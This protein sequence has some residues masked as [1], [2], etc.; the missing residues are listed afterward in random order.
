MFWMFG[1][2]IIGCGAT[3]LME[4]ITNFVPAYRL[5]GVVK[6]LT[7]VVSLMTAAALVTGNCVII[8]PAEQSSVIG[9]RFAEY[10]GL[11]VEEARGS[12]WRAAVHPDDLDAHVR[13][14]RASLASGEPIE[15]ETRFR[16]GQMGNIAGS[17]LAPCHCG[18]RGA[19]S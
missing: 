9:A 1:A 2:F 3:H 16:R 6:L 18:T 14:W 19:R 10:S 17:W 15:I 12:R 8:K 7:A 4:V 13:T 5:A 11:S